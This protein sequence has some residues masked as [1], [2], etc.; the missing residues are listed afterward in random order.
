MRRQPRFRRSR[1]CFLVGGTAAGRRLL[2]LAAER[3]GVTED[4]LAVLVF[5]MLVQPDAKR[6]AAEQAWP[7]LQIRTTG[8]RRQL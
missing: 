5:E 3:A 1:G 8:L 7:E 6:I 4:D 2:P